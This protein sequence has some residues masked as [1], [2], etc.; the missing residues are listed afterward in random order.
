MKRIIVVLLFLVFTASM[1]AQNAYNVSLIY[2]QPILNI[3][4]VSYLDPDQPNSQPILF[5]L[6]TEI[7][8]KHINDSAERASYELK[9]EFFWNG[10]FLTDTTL[11]PV[12]HPSESNE[13][14]GEFFT[15]NRDLIT[16]SSN[17]FFEA[18]GGFSFDDIMDSNSQFKDFVLETGKLPD[19]DYEIRITLIPDNPSL[20]T[21]AVTSRSFSVRGI[22]SVRIISPGVLAGSANIPTI[23]QPVLFNWNTSGFNNSF[24]VE[25]KEFDQTYELDPTNIEF[26]GRTVEEADVPNQTIYTPTYSFQ[27]NKYYAW[28]AKVLFV[29][30]ETLNQDNY[31]QYL[32]SN[33]YVFKFGCGPNTEV[34]NAFQEQFLNNLKNLNIAEINA[35]LE[36]GYFPKDGIN[37]NGKTYYGKEAVDMLRDLFMTYSIEVS[38]E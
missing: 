4:K 3:L 28:R 17:R 15:T 27:E 6:K 37:L 18:D 38:V 11:E 29:G 36:A 13:F 14:G 32:S 7:A 9:V 20:Y 33:Y 31:E 35:L 12:E 10:G 21:G 34:G 30:E 5:S 8:P 1:L 2:P 26:N 16:S 19:G 25:I 23:T 22:Q 24:S